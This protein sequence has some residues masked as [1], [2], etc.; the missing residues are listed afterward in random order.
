MCSPD[1]PPRMIPSLGPQAPRMSPVQGARE[2]SGPSIGA[3]T[4]PPISKPAESRSFEMRLGTY[5]APRIGIV[6]LLTGLVF[7]GNLAYEQYIS[8]LGP[9]G[10]VLLLYCASAL[11][12]GAGWWWQRKAAKESLKN[13]AQVLFAGGLAS[14]YFTT[15]AAHHIE[16]LRVIESPLLDGFLLL[17]CAAFIV[18]HADQIGRAHV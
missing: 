13:Y 8:R 14:L 4:V 9:A 3:A 11:L 7:F 10:K 6:V 12:L 18:F 5:W 16:Q 17:A 15:Y 2:A 1:L